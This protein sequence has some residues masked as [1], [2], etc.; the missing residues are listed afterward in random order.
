MNNILKQKKLKILLFL[1]IAII[2][3]NIIGLFL[4]SQ[5]ISLNTNNIVSEKWESGLTKYVFV[6][7]VNK[8]DKNLGQLISK[9]VINFEKNRKNIKNLDNNELRIL[10]NMFF[11][12]HGYN[13][14]DQSL[15]DY[16]SRFKWYN[17]NENTGPGFDELTEYEKKIVKSIIQVEDENKKRLVYKNNLTYP[18]K[19]IPKDVE[20][21][22]L[23]NFVD[24][25]PENDLKK[26]IS[27][28]K[29]FSVV[30]SVNAVYEIIK[31]FGI[32]IGSVKTAS[33][34][35]LPIDYSNELFPFEIFIE[36]SNINEEHLL[37]IFNR[38]EI[39]HNFGIFNHLILDNKIVI[40][41]IDNGLLICSSSDAINKISSTYEKKSQRYDF[42]SEIYN[43]SVLN[44]K[45]K[46]L[47]NIKVAIGIKD[48]GVKD[49]IANLYKQNKGYKAHIEGELTK[50]DQ[51]NTI[52]PYKGFITSLGYSFYKYYI[53][54]IK[55]WPVMLLHSAKSKDFKYSIIT[56]KV[57][58]EMEW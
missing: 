14:K 25:S 37:K 55:L 11:A 33:I 1:A 26:I 18:Q 35:Q 2:I 39:L 50:I 51:G 52:Y 10:R 41:F 58:I 22:I 15:K 21:F 44:I 48:I 20:N 53:P 49:I 36:A 31:Q 34:F 4:M 42:S 12:L 38:K 29:D 27:D 6:W 57:K 23:W 16:Y 19:L 24:F 8:V 30:N 43:S 40:G 32:E 54:D 46:Y 17:I 7:N 13:F 45:M 5:N 47:K 3:I 9:Y 56:N 28:T